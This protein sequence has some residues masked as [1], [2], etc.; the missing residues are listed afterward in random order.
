MFYEC[1]FEQVRKPSRR[2]DLRSLRCHNLICG[3]GFPAYPSPVKAGWKACSTKL[4][5]IGV[6]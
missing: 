5:P 4:L 1:I 6:L 2:L 3:E